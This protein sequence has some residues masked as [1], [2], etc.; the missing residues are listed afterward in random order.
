MNAAVVY[1]SMFGNTRAIAMAVADGLAEH[2]DVTTFNVVD[3]PN[4]FDAGTRLL[5]VGGPTHAF[6]LSR[7]ST[8]RSAVD[9]GALGID[10]DRPGL[11]EW[12]ASLSP[13][14]PELAVAIFDTRL[15]KPR[16]L[17]GSAARS[18][19]RLLR[20][21]GLARVTPPVSFFVTGVDGP[22]VDGE[23]DRARRW[24]ATLTAQVATAELDD[25]R[26]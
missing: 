11:R 8:R 2:A 19:E 10:P 26:R 20:R 9:Q 14:H 4:R 1:E 21:L 25:R 17:P 5:V 16:W 24:G 13:T 15:V 22:L 18:A 23:I 3:A 12:L 7:A 6:G